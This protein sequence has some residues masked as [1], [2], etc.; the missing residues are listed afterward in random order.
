MG[1]DLNSVMGQIPGSNQQTQL[2]STPVTPRSVDGNDIQKQ[3]EV[4]CFEND[5]EFT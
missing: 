1:I 3:A 4:T 2:S 5:S